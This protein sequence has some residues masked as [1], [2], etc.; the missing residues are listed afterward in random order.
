M[1][2]SEPVLEDVFP[3]EESDSEASPLT[4]DDEGPKSSNVLQEVSSIELDETTSMMSMTSGVSYLEEA[5]RLSKMRDMNVLDLAKRYFALPDPTCCV[6]NVL[7]RSGPPS[8][9]R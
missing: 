2:S 9:V 3:K 1:A 6:R 4:S 8:E 7:N 5:R